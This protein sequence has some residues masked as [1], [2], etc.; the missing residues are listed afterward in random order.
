M[1]TTTEQGERTV[2]MA[3]VRS[4][5]GE[6]FARLTATDDHAAQVEGGIAGAW[7]YWMQDAQRQEVGEYAG[8]RSILRIAEDQVAMGAAIAVCSD[9]LRFNDGSEVAI[10]TAEQ[11]ARLFVPVERG[12]I[13]AG[14]SLTAYRAGRVHGELP[15][16]VVANAFDVE[17]GDD[18]HDVCSIF[19]G[20]PTRIVRAGGFVDQ[21]RFP[22]GSALDL[23]F[24]PPVVEGA[25]T[26][27]F[28][29][30]RLA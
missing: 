30:W 5:R 15:V 13:D 22:D 28:D 16:S 7:L 17:M 4:G 12:G 8:W 29:G 1:T 18:L 20:R 19:G 21:F 14:D 24:S 3:Q 11:I 23:Y 25:W 26:L 2:A 9:R 27:P 10:P 6:R